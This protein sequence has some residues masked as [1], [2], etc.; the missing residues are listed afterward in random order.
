MKKDIKTL[1]INKDAAFDVC[2]KIIIRIYSYIG[3]RLNITEALTSKV[4]IY[5]SKEVTILGGCPSDIT[6]HTLSLA[7]DDTKIFNEYIVIW[8]FEENYKQ[9][10]TELEC[11]PLTETF[12]GTFL[13]GMIH[14]FRHIMQLEYL[15]DIVTPDIVDHSKEFREL[16][17]NNAVSF[18]DNFYSEH[19]EEIEC[20]VNIILAHTVERYS[21]GTLFVKP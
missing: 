11:G 14:E 4:N 20:I 17:E 13:I 18:A 7:Y 21:R 19:S 3:E 15:T 6:W 10:T 12:M 5:E 9:I 8:N 16:I 2:K 1:K